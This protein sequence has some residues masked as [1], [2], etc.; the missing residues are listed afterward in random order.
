MRNYVCKIDHTVCAFCGEP[1]EITNVKAGKRKYHLDC[2]KLV[3]YESKVRNRKRSYKK[4]PSWKLES[5]LTKCHCITC[6]KT[7]FKRNARHDSMCPV[8]ARRAENDYTGGEGWFPDYLDKIEDD[9]I[10][11]EAV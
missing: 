1:M 9:E 11:A 6:G 5:D 2:A 3:H 7:H 10:Y 8:C 4:I